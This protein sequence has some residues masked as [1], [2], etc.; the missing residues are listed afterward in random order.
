MSAKD[1]DEQ[2][3]RIEHPVDDADEQ[4]ARLHVQALTHAGDE[5][6]AGDQLWERR[7]LGEAA[8]TNL[9]PSSRG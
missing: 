7:R 1:F 9:P 5:H 2:H 8:P 4:R 3:A 6:A